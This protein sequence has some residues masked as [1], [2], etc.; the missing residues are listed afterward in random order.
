[1]SVYDEDINVPDAEKR[2]YLTVKFHWCR[3]GMNNP[4][5][6]E[7][8]S[9]MQQLYLTYHWVETLDADEGDYSVSQ[10][11]T[12]ALAAEIFGL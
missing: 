11:F 6:H 9:I 7:V 2:A 8:H 10:V 1:M 12:K 5:I 3:E 4:H